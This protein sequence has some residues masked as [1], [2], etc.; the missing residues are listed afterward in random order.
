MGLAGT[1]LILAGGTITRWVAYPNARILIHQPRSAR[2][3]T[4]TN[5]RC[6]NDG[7]RGYA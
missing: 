7:S 3:R 5:Y 6:I 2:I 1:S 4:N